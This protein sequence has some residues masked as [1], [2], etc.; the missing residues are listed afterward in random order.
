M[1][2]K[3]KSL[4]VYKMKKKWKQKIAVLMA[5]V[6]CSLHSLTCV[7]VCAGVKRRTEKEMSTSVSSYSNASK[8]N[9][10]V[11]QAKNQDQKLDENS[12]LD[13]KLN[14]HLLWKFFDG[15]LTISGEGTMPDWEFENYHTIPWYDFRENID[16]V[17]IKN[18]VV[19]IGSRAFFEC[20]NLVRVNISDSVITIGNMAFWGCSGLK[21]I[22]ISDNV[23]DIGSQAFAYCDS[24]IDSIPIKREAINDHIKWELTN[25][26][27]LT[28]TGEGPMPD[29]DVYFV[30]WIIYRQDIKEIVID[31]RI[32]TIGSYAF[33]ECT[34]LMGIKIPEKITSI[35]ARAFSGCSKLEKVELPDSISLI[36]HHAFSETA[37]SSVTIPASVTLLGQKAFPE[38]TEISYQKRTD[39]VGKQI[40]A[41]GKTK[42]TSTENDHGQDYDTYG[43]VVKSY[44]Y[45]G[46]D[47]TVY[48]TEYT[49]EQVIIEQY[50]RE[51][52]SFIK[53]WKVPMELP[54]FGGFYA[55]KDALYFVFGKD[56]PKENDG[57]E[58]M[59]IVKYTKDM[60][61][62]SSVSLYGI[63]TISPFAYC[64][65]RMDEQDDYLYIHTGHSMYKSPDG[66]N[67]QANMTVIID[68]KNMLLS[69]YGVLV[70]KDTVGY[71]SHSFNQFVKADGEALIMVDQG[72]AYPREVV[73]TV[74][75]A[76]DVLNNPVAVTLLSIPGDTGDNYTGVS[77]GGLEYS[78]S[79]YLVAGNCI[80]F[81]HFKYSKTRNIFLS[82]VNKNDLTE[83][84]DFIQVTDYEEGDTY[85]AS[86]PQLVKLSDDLFVVMWEEM[87]GEA[88]NYSTASG[89]IKAAFFDGKG[90]PIGNKHI[91]SFDG[92]LSDCQ[93][94]LLNDCVTWYSASDN[95]LNF[96]DF[97]A[98]YP[99]S[100][101]DFEVKKTTFKNSNS[102]N[103]NS[104]SSSSSS[105]SGGGGSS[106]GGARK[107]SSSGTGP[108]ASSLQTTGISLYLG[109][110]EMDGQFWKLRIGQNQYAQSQWAMIDGK[111]YIFNQD[112]HMLTGWQNIDNCWYMLNHDGAMLTGWLL[113]GGK[114]YYLMPDGSM[115][116]GWIY[117]NNHWYCLAADGTMYSSTITP[118]GYLVNADGEW[119]EGFNTVLH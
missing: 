27:K 81:D 38:G 41:T 39:E 30:P 24:L 59:R 88:I 58:V 64:S 16:E 8:S 48:R 55:G 34:E 73:M 31:D 9:T 49:S 111:W 89:T 80:D 18:G 21:N 95:R 17:V 20:K 97:P 110:W 33:Y 94:I 77:I 112:G 107:S 14:D 70:S 10:I 12:S 72:D 103:N 54:K 22:N 92:S 56:N 29:W 86:T 35:G 67:H 50:H 75:Q 47:E 118:D 7:K 52:Y 65:L 109:L 19:S 43:S 71:T 82:V 117:V 113:Y 45:E 102:S 69:Y 40:K 83:K 26:G 115:A 37:I 119:I 79:A 23:T 66:K 98:K 61:R 87:L 106:G 3:F 100:S 74:A 96:Y 44:L 116:K 53:S 104:N 57:V 78:N 99:D 25:K 28:I 2:N 13:G 11:K 84:A 108:G 1:K 76:D 63:N 42:F 6:L 36:N 91:Y 62:L 5:I 93:P 32:N 15:T 4:G 46:E 68:A 105:S 60:R 90:K 101:A 114:W 51:N 85:S